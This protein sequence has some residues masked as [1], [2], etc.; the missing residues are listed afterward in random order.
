MMLITRRAIFRTVGALGLGLLCTSCTSMSLFDGSLEQADNFK[1]IEDYIPHFYHYLPDIQTDRIAIRM[2]E[3]DLPLV[4]F[5]SGTLSVFCA[6]SNF[7][8]NTMMLNVAWN[9]QQ[10]KSEDDAKNVLFVSCKMRGEQILGRYMSRET[11]IPFYNIIDYKLTEND[12][13]IIKQEVERLKSL[14]CKLYIMESHKGVK[15]SE[16]RRQIEEHSDIFKPDLV[17]IDHMSNLVSDRRWENRPDLERADIARDLKYMGMQFGFAIAVGEKLPSLPVNCV[18]GHET[19]SV[20][21]YGWS[22]N[23]PAELDY[24]YAVMLDLQQPGALL[25]VS[26]VKSRFD[27]YNEIFENGK[28]QITVDVYPEI[29]LI[30][31][32]GCPFGH[33]EMFIRAL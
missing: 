2:T 19:I 25:N 3:R 16:I 10:A 11:R 21:D 28:R 23:Y 9:A 32:K 20:S 14:D 30:K 7:T 13:V 18:R 6:E 12:V 4:K 15:V 8:T 33:F 1:S 22:V 29:N 26:V 24:I 17:V 31:H 5:R 27:H